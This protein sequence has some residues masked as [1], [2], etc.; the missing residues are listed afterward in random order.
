[1]NA[2]SLREEIEIELEHMAATLA[3]LRTIGELTAAREPT[4]IEKAAAGAF[5]GQ[6]YSGLEN[7]LKRTCRHLGVVVP[8]SPKWHEELFRMFC[9]PP[10]HG[11]PLLLGTD[12]E[13]ELA[14]YR[15]F[16]HLFVHGYAILL[17]W[18]RI[19]EGVGRA[20][21]VFDRFSCAVRDWL[22]TLDIGD[23]PVANGGGSGGAV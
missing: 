12:L 19:K 6:L 3:E 20:Q 14:D 4:N 16:R 23:D 1:M 5:L 7:I 18:A 13:E 17:D 2:D 8:D 15:R 11:L 22:Q 21:G 9:N 10:T